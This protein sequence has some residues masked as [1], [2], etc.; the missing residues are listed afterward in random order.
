MNNLMCDIWYSMKR[1]V[2]WTSTNCLISDKHIYMYM[3]ITGWRSKTEY[4]DLHTTG[5]AG[6]FFQVCTKVTG[7]FLIIFVWHSFCCCTCTFLHVISIR[8]SICFFFIIYAI[9]LLFFVYFIIFMCMFIITR[10]YWDGLFTK[11]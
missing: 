11:K 10:L 4:E 2:R 9:F 5:F 7:A 8:G 1:S 3:K 6:V